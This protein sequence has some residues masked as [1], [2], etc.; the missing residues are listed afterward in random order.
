L[1]NPMIRANEEIVG[2][3]LSHIQEHKNLYQT[4]EPI[5]SQI[6]G[7]P[8]NQTPPPPGP[9]AM[10]PELVQNEPVPGSENLPEGAPLPPQAAPQPLPSTGQMG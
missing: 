7:D 10:P 9:E 8:P 4:Q 6:A 1:S 3:I 5:W 2:Q